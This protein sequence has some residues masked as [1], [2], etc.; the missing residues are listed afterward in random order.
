MFIALVEA[1]RPLGRTARRRAAKLL[2]LLASLG[3]SFGF[4][5]AVITVAHAGWFRLPAGVQD[6]G[7][8]TVLRRTAGGVQPLARVDLE[9]IAARLP[10]ISWFSAGHKEVEARGPS[11]TVDVLAAHLVSG[12]FFDAL[13]VSPGRGVLSTSTE[14][15]PGVVIG[16]TLWRSSYSRGEVAGT[17]L[18]V[19][20]GPSLPIVGVAPPAFVGI[21]QSRPDVWILN[22]PLELT[23]Y[24]FQFETDEATRRQIARRSPAVTVFGVVPV[25]EDIDGVLAEA[26]ALLEDYRFDTKPIRVKGPTQQETSAEGNAPVK[27][28]LVMFAF[29]VND[30]DRLEVTM[31]LETDPDRRH[32][33]VQKT[34]WLVGIVALLLVLV[35]ISVVEFLMA[36][37]VSREDEQKV[38]IAVG[39]TP[40]DVFRSAIVENAL[41]VGAISAVAWFSSGYVLDV[42]L[43]VE[44]F[45]TY[46]GAGLGASRLT[47]MAIGGV[48]L[49]LAFLGCMAY[50]SWLVSRT[51]LALSHSAPWL[52]R[53]IRQVLLFVG[54]ASLLFV[55]S[56]ASRYIGDARVSLGFTNTAASMVTA[57]RPPAGT[58][59][60]WQ[61]EPAKA[62]VDAVEAIPG[63]RRAAS[64]E[65]EPLAA[66]DAIQQYRRN[67]VG[68]PE[69]ADTPFY[70]NAV[71]AGYFSTLGIELLAGR[72]FDAEKRNE[73]VVSLSAAETLGGV[74]AVLGSPLVTSSQFDGESETT[75]VGVVGDA[76][77]GGY[78][79]LGNRVVYSPMQMLFNQQKWLVDAEPTVDVADAL[80]QL[81][82]F[83]GWDIT[84]VGTPE[85]VFRE[86]FLARRSVEIV[87][88]VAA[89]FALLLALAGIANSLARSIAEARSPIGIRFALG[90]TPR[91]LARDYLGTSLRDLAVAGLVVCAAAL[92]AKLAAPAFAAVLELWLLLPALACLIAVCALLSYA[93]V[94]Q[95]ARR[96][97]VGQCAGAFGA[98]ATGVACQKSWSSSGR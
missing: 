5:A 83:A 42:L 62:A 79:G 91:E 50:V 48:L 46:L 77:Y 36:E 81:P 32:E 71:T 93:L 76:P 72:A 7:Y 57:Y 74:E 23:G 41:L 68:R 88:S 39:A 22:P 63:I 94:G 20:D 43:R 6:Q 25:G 86:Q 47:G 85:S 69:L 33:V 89:A 59:S 3:V 56:L 78:A 2:Y 82:G 27:T 9:E 97:S 31:G 35:L 95:L 1:L 40:G 73:V 11:G 16:D 87:L 58:A 51:S 75:V 66:P 80:R 30:S 45:A 67:V 64:M 15:A 19:Q 98:G 26:G 37:N 18:Q 54:T 4:V 28:M 96:S 52:R 13:G 53:S 61:W 29:G 34:T 44:P 24:R 49:A 65:L 70:G 92:A 38:R 17:F 60:E 8:V 55:L 21:L 10:H 12:G 14:G 90:A 84:H